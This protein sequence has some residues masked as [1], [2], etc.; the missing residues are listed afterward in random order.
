ML[1]TKPLQM[2][3]EETPIK[4][5]EPPDDESKEPEDEE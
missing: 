3:E 2:Q 5:V 4:T 1:K